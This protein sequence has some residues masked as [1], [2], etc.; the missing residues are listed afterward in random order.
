MVVFDANFLLLLLD[1]EARPPNDPETGEP[2]PRCKDRIENLI[3][4]FEQDG[5]KVLIPT[6]ALSEILV[7]AG[8][9]GPAY[10]E[11]LN[12]SARFRIVPFDMRAAVELAQMNRQ[13]LEAGDKKSGRAAAWS[14]IKFDRQILAI[15]RVEGAGVV[16][17]DDEGLRR[18]GQTAGMKVIGISELPLPPEDPQQQLFSAKPS[19]DET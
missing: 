2:V 4:T 3:A 15:A 19:L 8:A 18:F 5:T 13:A 7:R 11:T 16:Y 9:A 14:K 12:G 6:P 10:L 17:S 1:P